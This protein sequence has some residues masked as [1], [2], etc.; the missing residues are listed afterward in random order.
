MSDE[1][2]PHYDAGLLEITAGM[3]GKPKA[4]M[5]APASTTD[6][7][8]VTPLGDGF[9]V[10]GPTVNNSGGKWSRLITP[11]AAETPPDPASLGR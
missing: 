4:K 9:E 7:Q 10:K 11:D 6:C 2:P 1:I 5:N 8:S 3:H